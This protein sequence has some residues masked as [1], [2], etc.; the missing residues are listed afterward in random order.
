M[1]TKPIEQR[2]QDLFIEFDQ[3]GNYTQ[4]HWLLNL[5][6]NQYVRLYRALYEIWNYRSG[7]SREA[8]LKICPF[9]GPFER[10]FQGPVYYED[11]T[12]EQI[13]NACTCAFETMIF[14]GVDEDHRKIGAF[15]ALSAL[16]IVSTGARQA[17]PWLYESIVY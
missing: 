7:L 14:S 6:L 4:S 16:T 8:R 1:R 15:H 10:I 13:K 17:M 2:I 3:L 5:N 12:I 9:Y 11:L